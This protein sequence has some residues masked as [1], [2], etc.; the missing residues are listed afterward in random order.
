M[1]V[2]K[3]MSTCAVSVAVAIVNDISHLSRQLCMI[4]KVSNY[5]VPVF[6]FASSTVRIYDVTATTR[7]AEEPHATAE[8]W[9][10]KN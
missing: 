2:V 6:R 7:K 10:I 3:E 1:L 4:F 9:H 5:F 8:K